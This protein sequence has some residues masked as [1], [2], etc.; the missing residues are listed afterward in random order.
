M[1]EEAREDAEATARVAETSA[2]AVVV[3]LRHIAQHEPFVDA[4]SDTGERD[5]SHFQRIAQARLVDKSELLKMAE[6][7][8]ARSVSALFPYVA[9]MPHLDPVR[10]SVL[11]H[12]ALVIKLGP[13]LECK[14]LWDAISR[15]ATDELAWYDA[16]DELMMTRWP[17]SAKE[18]DDRRRVLELHRMMLTGKE[19]NSWVH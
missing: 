10:L 11:A 7:N 17:V 15:A 19:P 12:V 16:A 14:P 9:T 5:I 18:R 6:K 8:L 13:L 3:A 1:I 2:Q 4:P